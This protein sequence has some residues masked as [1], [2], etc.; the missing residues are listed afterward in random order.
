MI[1][2]YENKELWPVLIDT[3]PE[4]L[5]GSFGRTTRELLCF[6]ASPP[7]VVAIQHFKFVRVGKRNR[8]RWIVE[9][10]YFRLGVAER[11]PD[12]HTVRIRIACLS[13]IHPV[14][15]NRVGDSAVFVSGRHAWSEVAKH[16][17]NF[18][19]VR[20]APAFKL[21]RVGIRRPV[22]EIINVNFALASLRFEPRPGPGAPAER[23]IAGEVAGGTKRFSIGTTGIGGQYLIRVIA[24]S[25]VNAFLV[26]RCG[27]SC[28]EECALV[29]I[30]ANQNRSVVIASFFV[31]VVLIARKDVAIK[32]GPE[33][34]ARSRRR[35]LE[36]GLGGHFSRVCD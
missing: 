8:F 34:A 4:T 11:R 18:R 27:G 22:T 31:E 35:S 9:I 36:N 25:G 7:G 30:S 24:V 20:S 26:S 16:V 3:N 19:A 5:V 15:R 21:R 1:Q 23:G 14:R 29:R 10:H 33:T 28:D 32:V 13:K 6:L 2:L 12:G 17:G